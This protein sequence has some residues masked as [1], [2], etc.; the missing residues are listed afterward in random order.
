MSQFASLFAGLV[1]INCPGPRVSI[2]HRIATRYSFGDGS[3]SEGRI[4][5]GIRF[6][7]DSGGMFLTGLILMAIVPMK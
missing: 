4:A 7:A 6:R 2:G 3:Q 5:E 1:Q